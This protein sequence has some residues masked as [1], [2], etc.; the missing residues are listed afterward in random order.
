LSA[1]PFRLVT[2]S[3]MFCG[4]YD[5][6]RRLVKTTKAEVIF[7]TCARYNGDRVHLPLGFGSCM[8]FAART[9][10]HPLR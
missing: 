4:E 10:R 3:W 9:V 5:S 7:E 1:V 2:G 6:Q 8:R